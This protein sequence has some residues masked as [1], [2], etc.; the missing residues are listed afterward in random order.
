MLWKGTPHTVRHHPGSMHLRQVKSSL[1][2]RVGWDGSLRDELR[3]AKVAALFGVD[4]YEA[5]FVG[6]PDDVLQGGAR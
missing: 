6:Q 2:H 4:V 1:K 5:P 3:S